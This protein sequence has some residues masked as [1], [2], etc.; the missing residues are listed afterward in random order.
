MVYGC[1]FYQINAVVITDKGRIG[2]A[3]ALSMKVPS[4]FFSAFLHGASFDTVFVCVGYV[5]S[6]VIRVKILAC[7]EEVMGVLF[8]WWWW[9]WWWW[10]WFTWKLEVPFVVWLCPLYSN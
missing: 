4:R 6:L 8:M 1:C 3:Q 7:D 10:R 9:W 5:P 2:S